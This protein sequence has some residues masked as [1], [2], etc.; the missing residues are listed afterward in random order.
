MHVTM[1]PHPDA[2]DATPVTISCESYLHVQ[3]VVQVLVDLL[4]VPVLAQ[5]AT[6]HSEAPQPQHLGGQA[7]L[8]GTVTLTWRG[9]QVGETVSW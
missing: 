3:V 5:Q 1:M 4:A 6:Q 7:G 2:V 9:R 8:T